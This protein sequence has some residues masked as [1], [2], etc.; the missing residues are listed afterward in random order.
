[1]D[2]PVI[3]PGAAPNATPKIDDNS[4][5]RLLTRVA[6]IFSYAISVATSKSL[7]GSTIITSQMPVD[8]WHEVI[9]GNGGM[10]RSMLKLEG[11]RCSP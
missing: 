7:G 9:A 3:A 11:R 6:M 1:L 10:S 2:T 5:F 4:N 8:H